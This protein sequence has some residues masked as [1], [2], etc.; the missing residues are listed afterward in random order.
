[1]QIDF[2]RRQISIV[3]PDKI[4]AGIH[5]PTE[6]SFIVN[7]DQAIYP[8]AVRPGLEALQFIVG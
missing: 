5:S 6:L 4:S 1:M 2:E 8:N 7:F 3:N